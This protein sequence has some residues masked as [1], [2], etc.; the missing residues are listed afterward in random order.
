MSHCDRAPP[1]SRGSAATK[2][3]RLGG[4]EDA[5]SEPP[6]GCAPSLWRLAALRRDQQTRDCLSHP[7]SALTQ[8][9]RRPHRPVVVKRL[10]RSCASLRSLRDDDAAPMRLFA[11]VVFADQSRPDGR[12]CAAKTT[13]SPKP[14]ARG[15]V[16]PREQSERPAQRAWA[17][18]G[19]RLRHAQGLAPSFP[20]RLEAKRPPRLLLLSAQANLP[21][22]VSA[23]SSRIPHAH[24]P[25]PDA[26]RA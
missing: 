16:K 12:L 21:L 25:P 24:R 9:R 19:A 22:N 13:E 26:R 6:R 14:E 23:L 4:C 18:R 2:R 7:C 15:P 1:S 11:T 10:R 8:R 3:S 5:Q 20:R 17:L